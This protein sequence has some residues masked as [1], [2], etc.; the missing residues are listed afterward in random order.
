M[1]SNTSQNF[2]VYAVEYCYFDP[3]GNAIYF[4][5]TYLRTDDDGIPNT[6]PNPDVDANIDI[7]LHAVSHPD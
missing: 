5:V 2:Y 3:Y 1:D 6:Q 7:D 4:T